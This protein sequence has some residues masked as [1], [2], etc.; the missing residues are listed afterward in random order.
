MS[1]DELF[2]FHLFDPDG[3]V[4]IAQRRL[5][6]WSQAGTIC[7]I[8]FRTCDS[9]P[10]AVL[11]AWFADRA[12]WLRTHGIDPDD[13]HPMTALQALGRRTA[14]EFLGQFWNRWHDALDAG[15]GACELRRGEHSAIIADSLHS[16]DGERYLLHDFVVMPNHVHALCSFA[17]DEAMLRQCE[18]WKR[19]TARRINERLGQRGRFWQKDAF[20]H[21][22]R[23]EEQFEFLRRYIAN[24]PK[25]A[26]LKV[27]E[28]VHYTRK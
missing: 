12:Q 24:N 25:Q 13:P 6:H 14:R 26:G 5:P 11:D 28:F 19:Y 2:P 21:L 18:S 4:R 17:D 7:F 27:G 10:Q 23:S 16:F 22:V 15:H 1:G 8:T 9:M 20:D 3:D